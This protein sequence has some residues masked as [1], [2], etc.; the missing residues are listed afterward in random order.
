MKYNFQSTYMAERNIRMRFANNVLAVKLTE[1]TLY[2]L[3]DLA[4][5]QITITVP[6]QVYDQI[7]QQAIFHL[8]AQ[9]RQQGSDYQ[10][11]DSEIEIDLQ[12]DGE[13]LLQIQS[14]E[15]KD[16]INLLDKLSQN[17]PNND[18][19]NTENWFALHIKQD[20]K[21]D[22]PNVDEGS[23]LKMG[24]STV[25]SVE[26]PDHVLVENPF[27]A[28]IKDFFEKQGF[29]LEVFD[30]QTQFQ[31]TYQS[32]SYEWVCMIKIREEF[33]QVFCYS[34]LPENIEESQRL[35]VCQQ[36]TKINYDLPIGSFEMDFSDGEL[37][38]KTYLDIGETVLT[39]DA[40]SNLYQA[41]LYSMEK[42]LPELLPLLA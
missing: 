10:F 21:I 24:Y 8:Q 2:F 22:L 5:L 20:V 19:L 7:D 35:N 6:K 41:N 17:D 37:R 4:K 13:F 42:Y 23:S 1:A 25:W 32:E 30:Q 12:L 39:G 18:F 11:S 15:S 28:K 40:L 36:I 9:N 29:V 34:F 26:R 33:K 14:K 27:F 16:F 31:F 38:F 3:D